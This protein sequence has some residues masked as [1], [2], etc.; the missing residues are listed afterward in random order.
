MSL[1]T[2]PSSNGW[3]IPLKRR[4][5]YAFISIQDNT[6]KNIKFSAVLRIRI[7]RNGSA[8]PDP[9]AHQ[10]VMDPQHWFA[11]IWSR[12]GCPLLNTASSAAPQISLCRRMLGLNPD[13]CNIFTDSQML[14]Y[15]VRSRLFSFHYWLKIWFRLLYKQCLSQ[16]YFII[17]CDF[18]RSI[19]FPRITYETLYPCP[20]M[21]VK[22]K[23][24]LLR[25][26][27]QQFE[28]AYSPN[29]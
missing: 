18:R 8:D 5:D 22:N 11:A 9:D 7:R 24:F 16:G 21:Y 2:P 14:F 6:S 29:T 26:T 15:S 27:S 28:T 23:P 13:C 10:N 12:F 4:K 19:F 3:T 20:Y 1:V 25:T 17:G